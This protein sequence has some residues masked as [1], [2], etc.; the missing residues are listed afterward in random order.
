VTPNPLDNLLGTDDMNSCPEATEEEANE[1]LHGVDNTGGL[2]PEH[3]PVSLRVRDDKIEQFD[4]ETGEVIRNE[5][6]DNLADEEADMIE[7]EE[8]IEEREEEDVFNAIADKVRPEVSEEIIEKTEAEDILGEAENIEESN[9][10]LSFDNY[11]GEE[12]IDEDINLSDI[13]DIKT[14]LK[15]GS[16]EDFDEKVENES[17]VE[18]VEDVEDIVEEPKE[19]KLELPE[20]DF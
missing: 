6:L 7:K 19:D 17:D 5:A 13:N 12:S 11:F 4:D 16:Q 18:N 2:E 14:E 10:D 20:F 3:N 9:N 15:N 1:L 8:I